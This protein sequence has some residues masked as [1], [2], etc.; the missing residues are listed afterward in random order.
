MKR[1]FTLLEMMVVV[2]VIGILV[3]MAVPNYSKAVELERWRA[4]RDILMTMYYGE[5]TH[6]FASNNGTYCD[7]TGGTNNGCTGPAPCW[8]DIHTEN[9]NL[10]SIPIT[11]T[12]T[13]SGPFTTFTGTA[14]HDPGGRCDS[15]SMSINEQRRFSGN[16]VVTDPL[17]KDAVGCQC[18]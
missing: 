2:V 16:W 12:A 1:G 5:R 9:P 17:T 13:S 6:M 3:A 4:A 10:K 14:Q 8:N 18:C 11:F 15:K 7:V